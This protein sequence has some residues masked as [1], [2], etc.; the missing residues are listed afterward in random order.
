ME[1]KKIL[2]VDDEEDI[3]ELLRFNLSREG[4][5]ISTAETGEEALKKA[6]KNNPD[7]IVLDL[8]LPGIDGLEVTRRLK[9]NPGTQAGQQCFRRHI[10]EFLQCTDARFLAHQLYGVGLDL[11]IQPLQ[12]Y[13]RFILPP[14]HAAESVLDKFFQML[15]VP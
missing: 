14:F 13:V 15:N 11:S 7:L 8:M 1:H 2:V 10:A 9:A 4:Y 6:E 12:A 3:L 5:K